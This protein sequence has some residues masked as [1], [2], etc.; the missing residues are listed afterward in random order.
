MSK[1]IDP[2]GGRTRRDTALEP[3][4]APIVSMSLRPG[5]P[6]RVG[7]P[8]EPASASPAVDEYAIQSWK[9]QPFSS[10]RQ[11]VPYFVASPNDRTAARQFPF[12]EALIFKWIGEAE[13]GGSPPFSPE[14]TFATG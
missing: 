9:S 14:H 13:I 10:E 3:H 2:M 12:D 7:A 1:S 8:A 5:I 11:P 6:G 4:P